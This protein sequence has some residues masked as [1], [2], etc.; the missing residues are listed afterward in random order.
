MMQ[1]DRF[2]LALSFVALVT[3]CGQSG[4]SSTVGSS[5]AAVSSVSVKDQCA[6]L[7]KANEAGYKKLTG[8]KDTDDLAKASSKITFDG[9]ADLGKLNIDDPRM[10]DSA[11][12][13]G[14]IRGVEIEPV[15]VEAR[16][17][18]AGA[19]RRAL[20]AL[21]VRLRTTTGRSKGDR[22]TSER[23]GTEVGD[24]SLL[25]G[26]CFGTETDSGLCAPGSSVDGR[27]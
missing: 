27:I 11:R 20:H 2:A 18:L 24:R 14:S 10:R 15:G 7:I 16:T 25:S 22:P 12:K 23:K 13:L 19:R 9:S 26:V 3:A 1:V 8:Q 4:T 17:F 6:P 5:S 21:R